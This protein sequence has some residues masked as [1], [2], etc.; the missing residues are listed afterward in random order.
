[1]QDGPWICDFDANISRLM[2]G[3]SLGDFIKHLVSENK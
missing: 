1:M 2:S 3:I